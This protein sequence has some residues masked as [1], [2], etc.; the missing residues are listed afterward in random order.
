[1]EL[2]RLGKKG[3]LSIPRSVLRQVGIAAEMPVLVEATDDGAILI[4]P[5]VAYPVEIYTAERIEEFLSADVAGPE[6]AERL[7]RALG[8]P[9]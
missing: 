6:R 4:R 9:E 2:V 7:R 5:A 1:M 3:Q 8:G